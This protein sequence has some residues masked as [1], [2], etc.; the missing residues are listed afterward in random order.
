MNGKRLRLTGQLLNDRIEL[1]KRLISLKTAQAVR[2]GVLTQQEVDE[3]D[4]QWK[5]DHQAEPVGVGN[6]ITWDNAQYVIEAFAPPDV[7]LRRAGTRTDP[8]LN[9]DN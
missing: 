4:E 6:T 2:T 7:I 1:L 8:S 3:S 9:Y 5:R